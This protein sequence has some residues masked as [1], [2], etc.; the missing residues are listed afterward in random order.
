MKSLNLLIIDDDIEVSRMLSRALKRYWN[1]IEVRHNANDGLKAIE[2]GNFDIVLTDWDCP[3]ENDG[4]KIIQES[5]IPVV[6]HTG[7][8]TVKNHLSDILSDIPVIEKPSDILE[9]NRT[10]EDTWKSLWFS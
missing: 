6:V 8:S 10:L 9:I 3:N 4:M 7:N 2:S 5:N 1:T